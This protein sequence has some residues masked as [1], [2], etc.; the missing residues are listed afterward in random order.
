MTV[1]NTMILGVFASVAQYERELICSRTK[2]ALDA[3]R[4]RGESKD[5]G[6]D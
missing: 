1:I 3:K 6:R 5:T 2:A 4:A